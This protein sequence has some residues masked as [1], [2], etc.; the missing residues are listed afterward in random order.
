MNECE[1]I[2]NAL[3]EAEKNTQASEL[4]IWLGDKWIEYNNLVRA[5]AD[6]KIAYDKSADVKKDKYDTFVAHQ[7]LLEKT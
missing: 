2:L 6:F 7:K 1:K 3:V 5:E 4:A